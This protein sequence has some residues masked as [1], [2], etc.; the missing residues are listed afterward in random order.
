MGKTLTTSAARSRPSLR[1]RSNV[2]L[3]EGAFQVR[4]RVFIS[5]PADYWLDARQ[6]DLK[7]GIVREIQKHGYVPEIFTDPKGTPSQ[8]GGKAWSADDADKIMRRCI[9]AAI[10]GLPRWIIPVDGGQLKLATEFCHYEA[11]VARTLGLPLLIV[12]QSD[13]SQRVVFDGRFGPQIG[14]FPPDADEGW[15]NKQEFRVVFDYW[16]R[17]LDERRDVFLGYCGTS[18]KTAQ[19]LKTFLLSLGVTVLDWRTDFSPARTI[20]NQ[21]EQAA[22][23]CSAG[24]FLFTKDDNLVDKGG[25]DKAVPRDNVVFEAGYFAS[26]KGKDHVLIIRQPGAKMPADLGGDIYA[27]LS[28]AGGIAPA[29][30]A[31][32][33]FLAGL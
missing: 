26:L 22:A 18:T 13:L 20:L 15:L 29:K 14:V 7:W 19:A 2:S 12:A 30:A 31:V 10:I 27:P 1:K 25:V 16:K 28:D 6:N 4:R 9:G 23:R 24:L 17:S 8:A 11:A 3:V 21:I 5:M 32:R 33:A